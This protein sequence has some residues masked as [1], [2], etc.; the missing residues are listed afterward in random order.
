MHNTRWRVSFY[1]PAI[2]DWLRR[3]QYWVP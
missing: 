1:S 3:N 2:L